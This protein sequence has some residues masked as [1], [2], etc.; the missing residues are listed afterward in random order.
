M[1]PSRLDLTGCSSTAARAVESSGVV[2][3]RQQLQDVGTLVRAAGV[4]V[5]ALVGAAPHLLDAVGR[6]TDDRGRA[7]GEPPL[8]IHFDRPRFPPFSPR[9]AESRV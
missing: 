6:A 9:Q 7:P 4:P 3:Q 8:Q 1:R 5:P 2:I